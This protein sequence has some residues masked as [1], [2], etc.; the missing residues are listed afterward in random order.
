MSYFLSTLYANKSANYFY[1]KGGMD[2]YDETSSSSD[3]SDVFEEQLKIQQ[4]QLK[5]EHQKVSFLKFCPRLLS[6]L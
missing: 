5:I 4:K 1:L 2:D 3:I 6:A